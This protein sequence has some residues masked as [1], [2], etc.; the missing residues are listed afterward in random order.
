MAGPPGRPR[1]ALVFLG[2]GT[3]PAAFSGTPF[4]LAQGFRALGVDVVHVDARL[5]PERESSL[6]DALAVQYAGVVQEPLPP[7]SLTRLVR[8][9]P[10]LARVRLA[11]LRLRLQ[12]VAR[13]VD[14]FVHIK[15]DAF[16]PVDR[17]QVCFD[18]LTAWQWFGDL[19]PE[20]VRRAPSTLAEARLAR[21][22]FATS[23][24]TAACY[25]THAAA[26]YAR[27]AGVDETHVHV[28]GIG[29]NIDAVTA[30]RDWS[31]PRF[32]FVG[33]DWERKNG[34]RLVR[35]FQAVRETH[36][37]A[38]LHLVGAI[39]LI[40]APGVVRHGRPSL[41]R[42]DDRARLRALFRRATCLALPSLR[43]A[44]GIAYVE[45]GAAGIPSIAGTVGGA[46]T[47]VGPGG[48]LVDPRDERAIT[49]ALLEL[50][51]PARAASLGRLAYG[52]AQRLTWPAVA[53]RVLRALA[54]PGL[55][56]TKLPNFL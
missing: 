49:A 48:L 19:G 47:M 10:E 12:R 50:A 46:A 25:A 6:F 21:E 37:R 13:S 35:A 26:A 17:P 38:E 45:A 43:E 34:A 42:D 1:V 7:S 39:P 11:S 33:G 44:A 29:R 51:D 56:H 15:A 5:P 16:A 32:L 4:G 20:D 40:D 18:D 28:V 2:D 54:L 9:S 55:S 30:S 22:Q 8:M 3:D 24:A 31:V 23:Q 14:G 41:R 52:N 36:P 27:E 53:G